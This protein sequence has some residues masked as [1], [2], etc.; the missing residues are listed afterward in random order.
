MPVE[1]KKPK[2]ERKAEGGEAPDEVADVNL[3]LPEAKEPKQNSEDRQRPKKETPVFDRSLR[4][5]VSGIP[6]T[7]DEATLKK[8]FEEC[9]EVANVKLLLDGQTWESRGIAFVTFKDE[10][11]VKA[12][13]EY[14]GEEYAG[15][16]LSVKRA[17]SKGGG[18]GFA[19][20]PGPKPDKCISVLLKRLSPD[21]TQTDLE[22]LFSDTRPVR[23]GLLMDKFTGMSRCT[24]RVDYKDG[25]GVDQAMKLYGS[26]LKG[27]PLNMDYVKFHEW[28]KPPPGC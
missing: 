5:F 27:R 11:G 9:G 21:V 15:K 8:D 13:L 18:K 4:V 7:I 23:V 22:D 14:D 19:G 1:S 17:E 10:A 2:K 25:S 28:S 24:A 6:K 16:K 20:G 3:I 12:A 26:T